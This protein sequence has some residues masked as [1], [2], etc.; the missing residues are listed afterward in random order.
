MAEAIWNG[1]TL[2]GADT[3][4]HVEGNIYFPNDAVN[5]DYLRHSRDVPITFCHWK[6]FS[7]YFDVIVDGEKNIGAAWRYEEQYEEVSLIKDHIAFW[8]G[9]EIRNAPQKGR[10]MVEPSTSHRGNKSGWEALC[11]LIRHSKGSTLEAEEIFKNTEITEE[12]FDLAWDMP[13]VQR[14]AK[15][16]R[17][18]IEK[19]TPLILK[20]SD[21]HPVQVF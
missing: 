21:R 19:R 18:S 13:D 17:W 12:G 11:W 5:W 14:Y 2:A 9:V 3:I 8:K 15:R 7:S 1:V 4:A 16:Y 10:G 6:G 20:R